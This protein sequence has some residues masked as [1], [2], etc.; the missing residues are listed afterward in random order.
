MDK[1]TTYT[2]KSHYPVLDG[3]RGTAALLVV[4][5]H[6]MESVT[7]D[8]SA[9]LLRYGYLAVD[10]FF[11]LSVSISSMSVIMVQPR[12]KIER[13]MHVSFDSLRHWRLV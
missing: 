9:N 13:D 8:Q 1:Q 3:L 12:C 5:F 6:L 7:A 11:A 4:M 10:F 2:G